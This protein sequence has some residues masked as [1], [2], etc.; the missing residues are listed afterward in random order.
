MWARSQASPTSC[1]HPNRDRRQL[2]PTAISR[3]T[4]GAGGGAAASSRGFRP[5]RTATCT[6]AT[7]RHLP[8]L[9]PGRGVRREVQP[10]LRRH[11]PDQGG[12]GVRRVDPG[13]RPLA[14]ASTGAG[15]AFYAS[16]YFEQLYEW[17]EQLIRDGQGVRLR[18]DGR[19]DPRVP[20]HAH[21]A[22]PEQPLPRPP[23][24]GEPRPV[25]ADAGGRV[26]RRRARPAGQDRHGLA[27]T[28]T[29]ATR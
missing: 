12:G 20:R 17:A 2:H 23:G 6:S 13:R 28:S 26:P 21:R 22:G 1:R 7:P 11:Q 27:R 8:E 4:S 3:R 29:C 15:T 5:S 18:P 24:R 9:R 19:G 25:P 10:A 14:R 16:D